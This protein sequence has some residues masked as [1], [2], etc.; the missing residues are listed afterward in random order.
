MFL[1]YQVNRSS[2]FRPTMK[3]RSW[4][5]WGYRNFQTSNIQSSLQWNGLLELVT[6][7][8]HYSNESMQ[9]CQATGVSCYIFDRPADLVIS[10]NKSCRQSRFFIPGASNKLEWA[11]HIKLLKGADLSKASPSRPSKDALSAS[12]SR[13]LVQDWRTNYIQLRNCKVQ[14]CSQKL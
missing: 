10:R 13:P 12:A 8:P 3:K 5:A 4:A 9:H 14:F 7:A 11:H 1:L 2:M 6:F